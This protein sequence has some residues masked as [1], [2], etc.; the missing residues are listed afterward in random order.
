MRVD[1]RN[2]RSS[3]PHDFSFTGMRS[4]MK[5]MKQF[6][7]SDRVKRKYK[8]LKQQWEDKIT[9]FETVEKATEE[10]KERHTEQEGRWRR[11]IEEEKEKIT[12]LEEEIKV[13]EDKHELELKRQE[14][15]AEKNAQS[16]VLREKSYKEEVATLEQEMRLIIHQSQQM[17]KENDAKLSKLA[18]ALDEFTTFLQPK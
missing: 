10:M 6:R 14:E 12:R 13:L 15:D 18:G 8:D 4:G 3:L 9:V 7:Q 2:K 17:K 11:S 5:L 1:W 16:S